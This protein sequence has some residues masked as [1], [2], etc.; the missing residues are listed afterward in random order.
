MASAVILTTQV[1]I[2]LS[3]FRGVELIPQNTFIATF[4]DDIDNTY[5]HRTDQW[6][7][8]KYEIPQ[9]TS[10]TSCLWI[11]LKYFSDGFIPLW[12]YCMRRDN[13]SNMECL[14]IGLKGVSSTLNRDIKTEGLLPWSRGCGSHFHPVDVELKP[15]H[16]RTWIHICWT[17]SYTQK[18]SKIYYNGKLVKKVADKAEKYSQGFIAGSKDVTA[19][20]F[21]IGQEQDKIKGGFDKRQVFNGQITELNIWGDELEDE[22]IANIASCKNL[23]RGDVISWE[24]DRFKWKNVIFE[25]DVDTSII[26]RPEKRFFIVPKRKFLFGTNGAKYICEKLG[27]TLAVPGSKE[28]NDDMIELIKSHQQCCS[29][30]YKK[31]YVETTGA[32]AC[33]M[34]DPV[35]WLGLRQY[36]SSWNT[37]DTSIRYEFKYS[38]WKSNMSSLRHV[39]SKCALLLTSGHWHVGSDQECEEVVHK[40]CPICSI[41]GT[42]IYTLKGMDDNAGWVDWNYYMHINK[43]HELEYYDGYKN[44]KIIR[45]NGTRKVLRKNTETLEQIELIPKKPKDINMS[46]LG[47]NKWKYC[48]SKDC[49]TKRRLSLSSCNYHKEFT[50]SSGHC[51]SQNSRCNHVT[52]C[53]DRSDE[54]N[55]TL[56]EISKS[57]QKSVAPQ[58][59]AEKDTVPLITSINILTIDSIDTLNMR[60]ALTL[61]IRIL[62]ADSRLKYRNLLTDGNKT[63]IP[64][65]VVDRMWLPLDNIFFPNSDVGSVYTDPHKDVVVQ[66]G[67]CSMK[68][69]EKNLRMKSDYSFDDESIDS[70][71]D[72]LYH[73]SNTCLEMAQIFKLQY[74]CIFNLFTF[75]FDRKE[76]IFRIKLKR[77]EK[78]TTNLVPSA[79]SV[80]YLGP[81]TVHQFRIGNIQNRRSQLEKDKTSF[82]FTISLYR[83]YNPQLISTFFPTFLLC[84]ISYSTLFI[85]LN[86]F[87]MRFQGSVIT[88]LVYESLLNSITTEFPETAYFKMIDVWFIWH[89]VAMFTIILFHILL[90]KFSHPQQHNFL[91]FIVLPKIV[92]EQVFPNKKREIIVVSCFKMELSVLHMN[93]IMVFLFLLFGITFYI[94]YLVIVVKDRFNGCAL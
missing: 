22:R 77:A 38:N 8:Y 35:A 44:T 92:T 48:T 36:G 13:S 54:E 50:C 47:R 59:K 80:I 40:L 46:P 68:N 16:H 65:E 52:D 49:N 91:N 78:V 7:E 51:V 32:Y 71:E 69:E 60:V 14:Q 10:F 41:K 86:N 31:K 90:H 30:K 43:S 82:L 79:Q 88:L 6:M 33:N 94:I 24:K 75:P 74:K 64:N 28:E 5:S 67:N 85:D 11:K 2:A 19:H 1:F 84:L 53:D 93:Y 73:G 76:C 58:P 25:Q 27:A 45:G 70:Y 34:D 66:K 9:F 15:F 39:N 18:L 37:I 72:I 26:C 55:C 89:T 12:S 20:A 23:V 3:L 29:C 83:N 87:T 81:R 62:W 42:P 61:Q 21:I 57:Y 4:Q 63:F 56:V 17:Y